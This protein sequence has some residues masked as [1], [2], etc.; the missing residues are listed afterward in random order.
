[1]YSIGQYFSILLLICGDIETNPGPNIRR[2]RIEGLLINARSLKNKIPQLHATLQLNKIDFVAVTETWLNAAVKTTELFDSSYQVYRKDRY[3]K[4]GGGILLAFKNWLKVT[5]RDDLISDSVVHNEILVVDILCEKLGKIG[6]LLCYRPPSD[7]SDE[8]LS[9]LRISL[10]RCS[11]ANFKN[12]CLLGDLNMPNIDWNR[13]VPSRYSAFDT[14]ICNLFQELNLIQ[15]NFNPSTKHGNILDVILTTFPQRIFNVHCEED[16]ID[17]DHYS[18]FFSMAVEVL[19]KSKVVNRLVYDYKRT[20]FIDLNS[21][22]SVFDLDVICDECSNDI[23]QLVCKWTAKIKSYIKAYVPFIKSKNLTSHPWIDCDIKHLSN[24]KETARRKA[25]NSNSEQHWAKYRQFRNMLKTAITRNYNQYLSR[26]AS[27]ITKNPKRAWNLIHT[28]TKNKRLPNIMHLDDQVAS[29][30]NQVANLFN[31]YF[32]STFTPPAQN[33][34]MPNISTRN[35]QGLFNLIFTP[36]DIVTVLK[37]LNIAKASGHDGLDARILKECANVLAPSLTRIFNYSIQLCKFPKSWKQANVIPVYKS[38]NIQDVRNYRPISLTCVVSKVFERCVYNK[39]APHLIEQIHNLQHGFMKGF[40]TTT[41]LLQ[42]YDEINA[43]IDNRGQVDTVFLDFSKAFDSIPH[44]LLIHKIQTFGIDGKLHLW[45]KDYLSNRQQ[46]VVIEGEKSVFVPVLSGVPQGSILGPLLFLLYIND[47]PSVISHS[48]KMA[49]YADDAKL[50]RPIETLSDSLSLQSDLD[51]IIEWSKSWQLKFNLKKCSIITFSRKRNNIHF[52]YNMNGFVLKHEQSIK[53]LGVTVESDLSW[54][55]HIESV[56]K[57]AY[58]VLWFLKRTLRNSVNSSVKSIF[59]TSLV[60]P[61]LEYGSIIWSVITKKNLKLLER[62]QRQATNYII[63]NSGLDY[64]SR[65][66]IC[67]M[68]PLSYR[69]EIL[70]I[71]FLYR[72]I[73]RNTLSII[74]DKIRFSG[75]RGK[76]LINDVNLGLL[77]I[78]NANSE[79]YKHFYTHR[80]VPLWNSVPCDIRSLEFRRNGAQFKRHLR[81]YFRK[82]VIERF[83]SENMCTWVSKCRCSNCR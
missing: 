78:Q 18:L 55:K 22:I 75:R 69:R 62:V 36:D 37:N 49:L 68:L 17:S 48:S 15:S 1:M 77:L 67:D 35:N 60:R 6:L 43:I 13:M 33:L 23:D 42:V 8:F 21:K 38:G 58:N 64:K 40:S 28:K 71:N 9:N 45:L 32:Y 63:G 53:D 74:L 12:L 46:R 14:E 73:H 65:L 5:L 61:H 50:Y 27:E 31:D 47:L 81:D 51:N 34:D 41:Q 3:D 30:P 76:L 56:V 24:R 80:I 29:N 57:K 19:A 10:H 26:E 11:E 66:K 72:S 52:Y 25:K 20:N 44:D 59:Y 83:D 39:I 82:L 79:I 2:D 16:V 70:D 7:F 54:D 4:R